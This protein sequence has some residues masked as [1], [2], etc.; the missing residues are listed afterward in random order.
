ME[1]SALNE[2]TVSHGPMPR[3]RGHH[4][5]KG[6]NTVRARDVE[7]LLGKHVFQAQEGSFTYELTAIVYY[8]H[9]IIT[10]KGKEVQHL[11]KKLLVVDEYWEESQ[12]SSRMLAMRG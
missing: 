8:V 7:W 11:A 3:L 6:R 12:F 9:K 4:R 1:C 2:I 10:W 5:G